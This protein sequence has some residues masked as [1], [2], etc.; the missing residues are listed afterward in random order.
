LKVP[1]AQ[2]TSLQA[3]LQDATPKPLRPDAM[4][5][6]S[7]APKFMVSL[8]KAYYGEQATKKEEFGYQYLPKIGTTENHGWGYMFD[9]MYAG[10]MEGLISFGMNPVANG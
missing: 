3:Y 8:L 10:G 7:N 6:W 9:R 4:N 1:R 2:Q 5:Y